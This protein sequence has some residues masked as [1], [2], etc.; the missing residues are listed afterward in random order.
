MTGR[1]ALASALAALLLPAPAPAKGVVKVVICGQ[2][3]CADV[4]RHARDTRLMDMGGAAGGPTANGPGFLRL[5]VSI[6]EGPDTVATL[7]QLYVPA[8]NIVAAQEDGGGWVWYSALPETTRILKRAARGMTPYPATRM[9]AAALRTT[10][11]PQPPKTAPAPAKTET[12]G[13][14]WWPLAAL[15]ILVGA[16]AARRVRR[17]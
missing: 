6:G 1:I 15:V 8:R 3:G 5:R 4:T 11:P 12:S 7:R 14:P 9:P 17:A 2:N 10:P 13:L 16:F